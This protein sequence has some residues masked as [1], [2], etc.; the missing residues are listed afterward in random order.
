MRRAI[1][2]LTFA[3]SFMLLAW[4]HAKAEDYDHLV[5]ALDSA[6]ADSVS[7]SGHIVYLD[8]WASWCVPCR[9]S[10]P[11]MHRLQAKY[12]DQG[13][14]VVAVNVDRD[15]KAAEAFL[16]TNGGDLSVIYDPKGHFARWL[17]LDVMPTSFI[18][19]RQGKLLQTNI[20]FSIE[21]GADVD[22][23][24]GTL[25]AKGVAK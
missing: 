12:Q 17:K 7:L 10:F 14:R 8:F 1:W 9:K 15:H 3:L 2:A 19:D 4:S 13:L 16:K 11:W 20:G 18:L 5:P 6:L 25:L 23:F 22:D 21:D 24:I